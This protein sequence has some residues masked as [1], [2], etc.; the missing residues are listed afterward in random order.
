MIAKC[1]S[2]IMRHWAHTHAKNC[3]PWWE[4]ETQWHRDWKNHFPP[5]S[6][7]VSH[8]AENGEIHRADVK[9]TTGIVIEFQHSAMTDQERLSREQ[10][11]KNLGLFRQICG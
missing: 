4:N 11:Y 6:R 10:F 9:T 1:G 3:D 5:D 7:E 8:T 2:R